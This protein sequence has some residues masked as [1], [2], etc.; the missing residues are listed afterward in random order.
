MGSRLRAGDASVGGRLL[1]A[2]PIDA[3]QG[4]Q[5]SGSVRAPGTPPLRERKRPVGMQAEH[6]PAARAYVLGRAPSR[7]ALPRRLRTDARPVG[8]ARV[9]AL[10]DHDVDAPVAAAPV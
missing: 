9:L 10:L 8:R 5:H 4:R 2:C 1:A 3:V 7:D 6:L